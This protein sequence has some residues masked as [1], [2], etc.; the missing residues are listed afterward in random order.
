MLNRFSHA[1]R[2]Q[3]GLIVV[4]VVAASAAACAPG[5]AATYTVG[6]VDV[7]RSGDAE[8]RFGVAQ[9]AEVVEDEGT[10]YLVED[11][12]IRLEIEVRESRLP[13]EL[14]N[15]TDQPLTMH[16]DDALFIDLRGAPHKVMRRHIR[17][18]DR[19][20]PQQPEVV[21]AGDTK[22]DFI[23][24]VHLVYLS[25]AAQWIEQPLFVPYRR[26]TL[27]ELQ[28]ALDNRGRTFGLF[29]PFEIGGDVYEYMI[30]FRITDVTL[31]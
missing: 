26:M 29:L 19:R 18:E 13:F 3:L 20:D 2:R 25:P 30:T 15:K 17:Y 8:S 10:S 12:L 1:V 21:R 23:L 6:L 9:Y 5:L 11:G 7:D 22:R 27:E 4:P 31:P 16:W 28:P 24:P 14:M